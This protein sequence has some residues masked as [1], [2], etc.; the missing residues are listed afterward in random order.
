VAT[1]IAADVA[2]DTED[3]ADRLGADLTTVGFDAVYGTASS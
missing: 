2:T 3:L 1:D